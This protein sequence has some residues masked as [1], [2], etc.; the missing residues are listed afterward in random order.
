[1]NTPADYAGANARRALTHC[2]KEKFI[3]ERVEHFCE[4]TTGVVG[5]KT[6]GQISEN[7]L[8]IF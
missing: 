5:R 8:N 4:K 1:M 2:V 6:T 7:N 3:N